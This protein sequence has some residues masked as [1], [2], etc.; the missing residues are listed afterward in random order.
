MTT[1]LTLS[2]R[3]AKTKQSVEDVA[4]RFVVASQSG[5]LK[6][7]LLHKL[8]AIDEA[9]AAQLTML[10]TWLTEIYLHALSSASDAATQAP[11]Q[12]ATWAPAA[13]LTPSLTDP[14]HGVRLGPEC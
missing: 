13:T 9:D 7:F 4:M 3:Y 14:Y 10:C 5:A 1:A 12:T 6:T 2:G 11:T 8:D